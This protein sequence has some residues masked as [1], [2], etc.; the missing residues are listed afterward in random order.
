MKKVLV[1]GVGGSGCAVSEM[2]SDAVK[3]NNNIGFLG[4]D[5]DI[6][7][8]EK[9]SG[10]KTLCLTEYSSLGKVIDALGKASV[11]EWFPCD[12]KDG[13]V[14]YFRSMEMG[15]GANGW[16]MKGLL[17][18]EYMLSDEEKRATLHKTLD[19]L[20]HRNGEELCDEAE[21]IVVGSLCGGT[22][23]ALFLPLA[24]YAKKYL[25]NK[26]GKEIR[27]SG[28]M[29]CP[30]IYEDCLTSEN[31]IKAY[32][33]AYAAMREFHA[34]DLVSKGYN[35]Y[36]GK[37]GKSKI[38]YKIGSEKSKGIGVLFDSRKDAFCERSAQPFDRLCLFNRIVG[39]HTVKAHE[40]MM[41]KV[42]GLIESETAERGENVYA[43]ISVSEVVF[44]YKS[45]LDYV[46]LKKTYDDIENEWLWLYSAS[47]K[48]ISA[49]Q[50]A[51]PAGE[52]ETARFASDFVRIY[53]TKLGV[54]KYSEYLAL[55]RDKGGF[56]DVLP[57]TDLKTPEITDDQV[58]GYIAD[59]TKAVCALFSSAALTAFREEL[60]FENCKLQPIGLFDSGRVKQEKTDAFFSKIEKCNTQL[61]DYWRNGAERTG[62][63]TEKILTSVF[64]EKGKLSLN[65]RLLSVEGTRLHPVTSLLVLSAFC[66]R[67]AAS[68]EKNTEGDDVFF[69]S[70]GGGY[71]PREVLKR[72]N[73]PKNIT[74]E[75][76]SALGF[77]RMT[78][79][80]GLKGQKTDKKI[81][82]A[83]HEI[84][85]D[86]GIA[87]KTIGKVFTSAVLARVSAAA[88]ELLQ[89]YRAAFDALPAILGDHKV[90]VKIALLNSTD[91]TC[92]RM[93]VGCD[94]D[95]KEEAYAIYAEE[96]RGNF[97]FDGVS[98]SVFDACL[99]SGDLGSLFGCLSEKRRA[100]VCEDPRMCALSHTD[101]LR[102]LHD[103][104]LF[105]GDYPQRSKY[106]D[107]KQA[108]SLTAL[109][110]N[111]EAKGD[112]REGKI[113]TQTITLVPKAAGEFAKKVVGKEALG[114][115]EATDKYLFL[116]GVAANPVTISDDIEANRI[117]SVKKVYNFDLHS[118]SGLDE[119]NAGS[120]YYKNYVKAQS[121]K[122]EQSTQMWN[123]HLCKDRFGEYLPFIN[124]QL[125]EAY[126]KG[127][128]K[129]VL[130]ML[131]K[132]ILFVTPNE[133]NYN[134][135]YYNEGDKQKEVLFEGAQV[136]LSKTE[137]LFGFA[138]ENATLAVQYAGKF[139]EALEK[140][141][142]RLPLNG[143]DNVDLPQIKEGILNSDIVDMLTGDMYAYVRSVKPIKPKSVI[144]FVVGLSD[145]E[146]LK[147][148]AENLVRVIGESLLFAVRYRTAGNAE[149]ERKL[150]SAVLDGIKNR[151]EERAKQKGQ[152]K[153]KEKSELFFHLLAKIVKPF[154]QDQ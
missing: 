23:S 59:V 68:Y 43:G 36:A 110:L 81:L 79:V 63:I 104:D 86:L 46:A 56:D 77:A 40:Q 122:E 82:K 134:A 140:E 20:V 50:T 88:E 147:S 31:K 127:V 87:E 29:S 58:D 95:T 25:K 85:D 69:A 38:K 132:G 121:V 28:L 152:R 78:E 57:E 75:C 96:N 116:Q 14:A 30:D 52:S 65:E 6:E 94:A 8:L 148:E 45:V 133:G 15:K 33:N 12:D 55:G 44:D 153:Y 26:Y 21:I 111:I 10:I 120:K 39:T 1:F 73:F 90:D 143:Y 37:T 19:D 114:L 4:I 131:N 154:D 89:K 150:Y 7:A 151:Y 5:T 102:V 135:F 32:A 137:D 49:A 145:E 118:F 138:R 130:Y 149:S 126:E 48:E 136:L 72:I 74:S 71:L 24:L 125:R 101:V 129:A 99:R 17:S 109:P 60:K 70:N 62:E 105:T 106:N 98:G 100:A 66:S 51:A 11:A 117:F 93:N 91:N 3:N 18:F 2:Y 107:L 16:R 9:V 76:Y 41:A 35:E 113:R 97:A 144:D 67:L 128:Y 139:D 141:A 92:T 54:E 64:A 83:F 115:Q 146:E 27:V 108:F 34:V 124:P 80:A 61:A 119:S 112:D 103:R 123:P 142:S 42:L 53:K 22:G 84:I 47:V 13:K